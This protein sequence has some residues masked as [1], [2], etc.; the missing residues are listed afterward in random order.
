M[1]V[2]ESGRI[3]IVTKEAMGA[4]VYAT[5]D[6]PELG[7]TVELERVGPA[8]MFLTDGAISPDG[9]QVAVR[10][11]TSFYLYDADAFL[12]QGT[13]GDAGTVYP[14]P[15]QP[16]GETLAYQL[17]GAGILVGSEGVEQP[18]YAIG[19]PATSSD[20]TVAPTPS[21]DESSGTP[22]ALGL[23]AILLVSGVAAL[24]MRKRGR[25]RQPSSP[26]T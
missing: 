22:W 15:L 18:I 3:F 9:S 12:S 25:V 11:Y 17:D 7:T 1:M 24:V 8:P 10:S 20:E 21:S 19:F 26:M 6:A 23:A 13:D 16:Q 2:D 5:P 14:L 4:G